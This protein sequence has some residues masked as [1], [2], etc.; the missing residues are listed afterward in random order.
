VDAPDGTEATPTVPSVSITDAST[1]GFPLESSISRAL[2]FNI[3][4]FDILLPP[5]INKSRERKSNS[6]F[7]IRPPGG[8]Y[9]A[10]GLF[11]DTS[12]YNGVAVA[13]ANSQEAG[14]RW[15]KI[16]QQ[17]GIKMGIKQEHEGY[18]K[19]W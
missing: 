13:T 2:H 12:A 3:C 17:L 8:K 7:I 18:R 11:Y 9:A 14:A 16:F 1:V 19:F 6:A 4:G 5:K 10:L 15:G